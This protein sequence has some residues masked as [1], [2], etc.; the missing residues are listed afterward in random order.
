MF[1]DDWILSY[2]RSGEC[3]VISRSWLRY[4]PVPVIPIVGA[5]KLSQF[6][7]NLASFDPPAPE[8]SRASR[9]LY[10]ASIRSAARKVTADLK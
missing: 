7:D 4:R 6:Q 10:R 9:W 5:R 1:A 2:L 8:R 3:F